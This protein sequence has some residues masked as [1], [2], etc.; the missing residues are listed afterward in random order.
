MQQYLGNPAEI[1]R[2]ENI[3]GVHHNI[4]RKKDE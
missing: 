2:F 3:P 4:R 1:I